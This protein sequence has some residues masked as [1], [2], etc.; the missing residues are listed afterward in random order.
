[1]AVYK[2]SIR[3]DMAEKDVEMQNVAAAVVEKKEEEKEGGGEQKKDG[4]TE[5]KELRLF[6]LRCK[7]RRAVRDC[8]TGITKFFSQKMGKTMSRHT[9]IAHCGK[10][11][12]NI[13]S[14]KKAP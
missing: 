11:G 3:T 5:V 2:N 13:R 14:F 4:T 12:C 10:C 7:L 6:C 9:W 1:M 8:D